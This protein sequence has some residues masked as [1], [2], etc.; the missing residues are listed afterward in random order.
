[1]SI[2]QLELRRTE[3]G[4]FLA[5]TS[6]GR[7]F[8]IGSLLYDIL[9]L[10]QQDLAPAEISD[11]LSTRGGTEA[12]S[13]EE[14]AQA[15]QRAEASF[16]PTENPKEEAIPDRSSYINFRIRLLKEGPLNRVVT[17][18]AGLFRKQLA[19]P[20]SVLSLVLTVW[21]FLSPAVPG[22]ALPD[23]Y[24]LPLLYGCL[25]LVFFFHELGHAA[26]TRFFGIR[27][28][29][30]SFGFYLVFPVFFADV[31]KIWA[32][33]S[34]KRIIVN[35]GGIY[36]QLLINIMLLGTYLAGFVE[37]GFLHS[38]I[39]TNLLVI[40][41]SLI[42]FLRYD[43]YWVYSD[44]FNIPNLMRRSFTYPYQLLTGNTAGKKT[45]WPLLVYGMLNYVV[46]IGGGF[47]I[48]R[49]V[50]HSIIDVVSSLLSSQ[51]PLALLW[52][53]GVDGLLRLLVTLVMAVFLFRVVLR[54]GGR[55][56]N[57]L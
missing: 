38:V 31:S 26:A 35:L 36:F 45:N 43:G 49:Y 10:R 6:G 51:A 44:Y 56:I 21:Y 20:L 54:N 12:L 42:P 50:T 39:L 8:Y 30:V 40:V 52:S 23:Y 14:V 4:K 37:Q 29:E 22:T 48:G 5:S 2:A 16:T 46:M 41:Y 25:F 11:R 28:S 47:F 19:I 24:R 32:L 18:L 17:P 34:R 33:G 27:P 7:Y 9:C 15:L 55:L 57:Y 53:H 13:P 1:M 3:D